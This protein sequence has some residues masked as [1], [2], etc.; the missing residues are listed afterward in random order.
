M[1]ALVVVLP[2]SSLAWGQEPY[3]QA[4]IS[5]SRNVNAD[6]YVIGRS[7]TLSRYAAPQCPTP[8]SVRKIRLFGGKQEGVD[9]IWIDNGKI[10]I[11]V[12]PTRGMG[13]LSVTMDGTRVLGWDSPVKEVVHPKFINLNSRGGLGWLEGFTE[14]LCRCGM[15]WN[16][17]A[18][19]D[20]FINN[21]GDEAT[22][23]LTLHGRIA[24]L[25]AQEVELIAERKAP[26]RVTLRSRVDEKMLYGPKLELT[27]E[28][29]TEPGSSA[30]RLQDAITNRGGQRQ[31]FEMLYHTNFGPPLLEEGS[32]FLAP[33][34][35][36]TPFNDHAAKDVQRYDQYSGP[37]PGFIEQVYGMVPLRDR[38]GRT[39]V[40]IRN[41][42]AD[43]AASLRFDTHELPFLTV[44]KNT[45]SREDGYVTGIEPG[46]NYPNHRR[47]ER[48]LGRVPTL[49]PGASHFM[50]IDFAIHVGTAE[51][52]QVTQEIARIQGDRRPLLKD[53]PEKKD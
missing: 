35:I 40:M 30:F 33:V 26:F 7:V 2:L 42:A 46:T 22:M 15:E 8:W 34:E 18:G 53:K 14:W 24:N 45:I 19:S 4:L 50:T 6:P 47:V 13:I 5:V 3:R 27:S 39:L 23:E 32:R 29:S 41:K 20:R 37:T 48:K 43:R 38:S 16:G 49:S 36:V 52:E 9:L 28:L 17:Q 12:I 44:W 25:P 10:Q 21:M 1:R 51:V 11:T 31:E